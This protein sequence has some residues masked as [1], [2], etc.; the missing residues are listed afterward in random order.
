LQNAP[1]TFSQPIEA[2]LPASALLAQDVRRALPQITLM[3]LPAVYGATDDANDKWKWYPRLDLLNSQ[4]TDQVFVAEIDNDGR[5]HL[6]FGDGECGRMP[7]AG[8]SFT[9]AYRVG[10]GTAGNVGAETI[11]FLVLRSAKLSGVTIEPCNPLPAQG[12]TAPEP[13]AEAR[14]F[15]PYVYRKQ[16]ERAITAGDYAEIAQRNR[17]IQRA[18]AVLRWTGSWYEAQ[19][20]IDPLG[21]EEADDALLDEIKGYLYRYRRM[22]HDLAVVPALYVPLDLEMTVC[23]LPHFMRGHVK[24]ALLERFS[25]QLMSNGQP[26]FFHPDNLTFGE[27][28]AVSKIVAAAQAIPGVESVTVTKLERLFEGENHELEKGLLP[29]GSMEI[30]QDDNDPSFPE[31]G[32]LTLVM[33]GGR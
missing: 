3:G 14:L 33:E 30:A 31:H 6:R 11:S 12:G 13:I 9:A 29:L 18:A 17:K 16:L 25:N 5:A 4:D 26:G 21:S 27:G 2:Q 10:N 23:V 1:V 7:D 28:V 19:V 15:A 22:G 8:M 20:A 24:A 32:K